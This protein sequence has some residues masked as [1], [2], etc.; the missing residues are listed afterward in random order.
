MSCFMILFYDPAYSLKWWIHDTIWIQPLLLFFDTLCR[1][2][3]PCWSFL[4]NNY[5]III[6]LNIFRNR[7]LMVVYPTLIRLMFHNICF[8]LSFLYPHFRIFLIDN[9]V[10]YSTILVLSWSA[11]VRISCNIVVRTDL[12]RGR[13]V[14]RDEAKYN[15]WSPIQRSLKWINWLTI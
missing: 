14:T 12:L 8:L 7:E 2:H 4:S 5:D 13:H 1:L 15:V 10:F 3:H 6:Y 9:G 11:K